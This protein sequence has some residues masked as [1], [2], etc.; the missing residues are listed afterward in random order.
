MEV[1][2]KYNAGGAFQTVLRQTSYMRSL[3]LQNLQSYATFHLS[4][5]HREK[6]RL[7]STWMQIKTQTN[8]LTRLYQT[9]EL[10]ARAKAEELRSLLWKWGI[11]HKEPDPQTKI[12]SLTLTF[13]HLSLK[14]TSVMLQYTTPC[15]TEHYCS[16][17]LKCLWLTVL[18]CVLWSGFQGF[19]FFNS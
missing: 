9:H 19:L 4:Q 13:V 2:P 17:S 6:L 14:Y 8:H 11:F 3:V 12:W 7:P 10:N 16:C 1:Q 15:V 18:S 5:W